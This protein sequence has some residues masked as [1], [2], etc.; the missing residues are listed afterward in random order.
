MPRKLREPRADLRRSGFTID[1]Q[2]GS[3]Q[4]WKHPQ[5][6]GIGAIVGGQASVA[7]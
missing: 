4:V 2:T 6:P 1:H 3:H 7:E 5:V